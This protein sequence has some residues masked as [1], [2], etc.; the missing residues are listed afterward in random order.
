MATDTTDDLPP[1]AP[2]PSVG[3]ARMDADGTLKLYLYT[4][5]ADG[6]I[7][8]M[9]MTVRPDDPRHAGF[10]AHLGGIQPGQARRIPPFPAPEIDPDSV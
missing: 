7:G 3:T 10:V 8:E 4:E 9:L 6:V 5:T 1:P 2:P